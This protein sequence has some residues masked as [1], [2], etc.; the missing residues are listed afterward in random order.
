MKLET[1]MRLCGFRKRLTINGY[2]TPKEYFEPM[3]LIQP[4]NPDFSKYAAIYW[5]PE[6]I[7][8]STGTASF[9][10]TVPQPLKSV[11]I[12][13]EGINYDGLIFLHEEKIQLPGREKN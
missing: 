2:S 5:K 4:E 10:F 12:K 3:Y 13:A 7:T 1:D 9:T 8:D 11:V 6:I